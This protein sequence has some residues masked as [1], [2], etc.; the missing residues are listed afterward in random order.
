MPPPTEDAL[1]I[2]ASVLMLLVSAAMVLSLLIL[3]LLRSTC[4][5]QVKV[6]KDIIRD[7]PANMRQ[8]LLMVPILNVIPVEP[9][10]TKE[11]TKSSAGGEGGNTPLK[12]QNFVS[13]SSVKAAPQQTSAL[14]APSQQDHPVPR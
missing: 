14:L 3:H 1:A 2:W 11:A 6:W 13:V 5:S 12:P 9:A 10:K 7:T 8:E 4:P